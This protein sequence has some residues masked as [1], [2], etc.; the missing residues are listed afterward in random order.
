[1]KNV[2]IRNSNRFKSVFVQVNLL[3]PLRANET[4]KNALLAMVLK[5]NNSKYKTERELERK[6]ASLYNTTLGA[7][8]EKINDYYNISFGLEIL[9]IKYISEDSINEAIGI[10]N[11]AICEPNIQN[12]KFDEETFELEKQALIERIEE[13]RDDKKKYALNS[14]EREMFRGTDYGSPILGNIEEIQKI[15]N[16]ELVE[17]YYDVLDNAKVLVTTVGNLGGMENVPEKT[18]DRISGKC[19]KNIAHINS[20][21][22]KEIEDK[23][24]ILVEEQDINQ[25]VLCIGLRIKNVTKQDLYKAMLYNTILGGTPSSKL[26]QNVREKESLA[27][28]AKSLYNR[29]KQVISMFAGIAPD[30]YEKAKT[31]MLEQIEIIKSGDVSDV[32]FNA[33]KESLISTYR[34]LQDSKVGQTKAIISNSI[35]FDEEVDFNK[36]MNEI[37][38]LTFEDVKELANRVVATNIFLLGGKANV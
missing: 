31:V 36:M 26:F 33:A 27:Y 8:V 24:E 6:L 25:S 13:E 16:E 34:E 7:S 2:I 37:D 14:L 12:G 35:Y 17:H 20:N 15:T 9:N 4:G 29:H 32:E 19:G 30:K 22:E 38:K 1:M 10:L 21:V 28:F 18:Y 5:K 3:L 11:A 23:L